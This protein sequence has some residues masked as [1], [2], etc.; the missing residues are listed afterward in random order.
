MDYEYPSSGV[1]GQGVYILSSWTVSSELLQN[2]FL[3]SASASASTLLLS[4][5]EQK[6]NSE[7]GG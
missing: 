5:L 3:A 2:L 1:S 4:I 7:G 6:V